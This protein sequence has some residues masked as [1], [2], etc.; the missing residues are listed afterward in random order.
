MITLLLFR[1]VP[2][3]MKTVSDQQTKDSLF[4]ILIFTG[5]PLLLASVLTPAIF[6]IGDKDME[7][8]YKIVWLTLCLPFII[9]FII[10][11]KNRRKQ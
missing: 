9:Y 8:A 10:V 2:K 3:K 5:M 1:F 11:N 6:I 4:T 7:L